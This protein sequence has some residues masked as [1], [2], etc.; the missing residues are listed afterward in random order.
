LGGA[1]ARAVAEQRRRSLGVCPCE[2]AA[3]SSEHRRK[4]QAE[5]KTSERARWAAVQRGHGASRARETGDGELEQR[6]HFHG[7]IKR[8]RG[9][10][11]RFGR[12]GAPRWQRATAYVTRVACVLCSVVKTL[13]CLSGRRKRRKPR[14]AE[15]DRG[16][17][18]M[19]RH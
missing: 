2:A 10:G 11:A 8:G 13:S 9:S 16:S 3:G 5:R 17:R 7:S 15:A 14:Q 19:R 4:W 6:R 1:L 18:V 12:L